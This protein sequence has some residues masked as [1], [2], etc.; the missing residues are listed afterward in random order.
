[1]LYLLVHRDTWSPMIIESEERAHRIEPKGNFDEYWIRI[2]QEVG[3]PFDF[4]P[5]IYYV[6][7]FGV[8]DQL[9][10]DHSDGVLKRRYE[11]GPMEKEEVFR[12]IEEFAIERF[13]SL[14]AMAIDLGRTPSFF[15]AYK[16]QGKTPGRKVLKEIED[17]YSVEI[18]NLFR[19]I[20]Y[21]SE[22][23][24]KVDK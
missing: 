16:A 1:M 23:K 20:M 22:K 2:P 18:K 6:F 14:S 7:E 5:G 9:V 15:S 13:G 21:G 3:Q 12:V 4:P 8:D 24:E 19:K 10:L 11:I 17:K